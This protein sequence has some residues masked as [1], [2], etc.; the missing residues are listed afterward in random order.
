MLPRVQI[1]PVAGSDLGSSKT[2]PCPLSWAFGGS[3]R[4]DGENPTEWVQGQDRT[5]PLSPPHTHTHPVTVCLWG[6][7]GPG[8]PP[9]PLKHSLAGSLQSMG[10]GVR[11]G[12]CL[13]TFGQMYI[14][15]FLTL[16]TCP[17]LFLPL[18]SLH[19]L[20]TKSFTENLFL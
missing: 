13:T 15:L 1:V 6:L 10:G 20:S 5:C 12:C 11:G 4:L 17:A 3:P 19:T 2:C 14:S 7:E 16:S 9:M 8:L 18:D